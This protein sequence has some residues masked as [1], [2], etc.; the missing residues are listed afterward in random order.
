MKKLLLALVAIAAAIYGLN[1]WYRHQVAKVPK[2]RV[3]AM[4][5]AM[6][7]DDRPTAIAV[8]AQNREKLDKALLAADESHF[9]TFWHDSGLAAGS[10]W[11]VT[12]VKAEPHGYDYLVT[13]ES[14]GRRV[15]LR[16]P[17]TAKIS[18]VPPL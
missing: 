10:A 8:W 11:V 13:V 15:V 18:F 9:Q 6:A 2:L 17:D 14:G 1:A 5:H 12:S 16:V 7:D 4:L 3:E